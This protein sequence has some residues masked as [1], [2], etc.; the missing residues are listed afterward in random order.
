MLIY[1]TPDGVDDHPSWDDVLDITRIEIIR[2][3]TGT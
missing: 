3:V 1:M 2:I